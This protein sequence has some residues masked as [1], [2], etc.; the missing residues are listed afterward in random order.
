MDLVTVGNTGNTGQVSGTSAGGE[1]GDSIVGAVDYTYQ[2]GK[3][4]V[5][6]GQYTEFLN[7]VARTDSY[8]L[9]NTNMASSNYGCKIARTGSSGDYL[10]SVE[11]AWADRPVNYVSWADAARFANWLHNGQPGLD[12]PVPQDAHSTEDGAYELNGATSNTA[13]M[14]VVRELD[15]LWAIP[16]E[17]EWYKAAYHKNDGPTGNYY[18]YPTRSDSTPNNTL[19]DPD[20]GNHAT[21]YDGGHT[22]GSPYY[23]TEVGAHENSA[24]PYGTFD[25]GGNVFEW[26]EAI[27]SASYRGLRGGALNSDSSD[28]HAANRAYG[29]YATFEYDYYGF[30]V[31]KVPEPAT[32]V[33]MLVGCFGML[34]RSR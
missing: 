10:Y 13:L 34:R 31:V 23:R 2:I 33:I 11:A 27:L 18:D 28:L 25:Q 22:I 30:R 9:Y 21:F 29:G 26:N 7:A 20:P 1:G 4:E 3:Y 6:A 16:T 8:S 12:T 19:V 32:I 17:D 14:A 5:T 15:A 24:S